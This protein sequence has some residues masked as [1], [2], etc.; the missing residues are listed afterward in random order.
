MKKEQPFLVITSFTCK[1]SDGAEEELSLTTSTSG[2][3]GKA[4]V[5]MVAKPEPKKRRVQVKTGPHH[6]ETVSVTDGWLPGV[7]C[8]LQAGCF[9]R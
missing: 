2:T 5:T 9:S 3:L 4:G 6:A 8:W 1:A 7:G